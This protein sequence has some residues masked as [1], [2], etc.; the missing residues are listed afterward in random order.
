MEAIASIDSKALI[1]Q[2]QFR[3]DSANRSPRQILSQA[4]T[5]SA[6]GSGLKTWSDWS[7]PASASSA[8]ARDPRLSRVVRR[9]NV[10]QVLR[11]AAG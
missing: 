11:S 3:V 7:Y 9:V 6:P 5:Q 8:I 1:P 2:D 10:F 4:E